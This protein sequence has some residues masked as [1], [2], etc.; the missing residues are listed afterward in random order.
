MSLTA[1]IN[2]IFEDKKPPKLFKEGRYVRLTMRDD[3][4]CSQCAPLDD[5][6]HD[7]SGDKVP[8]PPLH[9]LCRCQDISLGEVATVDNAS[10]L[11]KIATTGITASLRK[12]VIDDIDKAASLAEIRNILRRV[13]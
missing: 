9:P 7:G 1:N 13:L 5:V 6:I 12:E 10:V 8:L 4:V 3:K 2:I 11:A